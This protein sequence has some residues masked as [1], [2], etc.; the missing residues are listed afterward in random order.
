MCRIRIHT[1]FENLCE[2][3]NVQKKMN[4]QSVPLYYN[5]R[6]QWHRQKKLYCKCNHFFLFLLLKRWKK[7]GIKKACIPVQIEYFTVNIT[8]STKLNLS[9][10]NGHMVNMCCKMYVICVHCSRDMVRD[11]SG[12]IDFNE[13]STCAHILL[14]V[15]AGWKWSLKFSCFAVVCI[16]LAMP[17]G[18]HTSTL[19]MHSYFRWFIHSE[20]TQRDNAEYA[21]HVNKYN[22]QNVHT[23]TQYKVIW[24]HS[25]IYIG[26]KSTNKLNG[27]WKSTKFYILLYGILSN[28]VYKTA[29]ESL[30]VLYVSQVFEMLEYNWFDK[31]CMGMCK[32]R[33]E[34]EIS[35]EIE[36]LLKSGNDSQWM[37][38]KCYVTRIQS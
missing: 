17:N 16:H 7:I 21:T 14:P 38:I 37:L 24:H 28:H 22:K 8:N 6:Q 5:K 2:W 30:T 13:F 11:T 23:N 33:I 20:W 10:M 3:M 1:V 36:S 18:Q 12:S 31:M 32:T 9:K 26:K 27:R 4:T 29:K 15:V 25:C 35:D 34:Q 19:F